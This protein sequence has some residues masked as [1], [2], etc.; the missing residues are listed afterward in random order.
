[1]AETKMT[2]QIIL[3][4][5]HLS[6]SNKKISFFGKQSICGTRRMEKSKQNYDED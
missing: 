1:M 3:S 4:L 5:S 2:H 6:L